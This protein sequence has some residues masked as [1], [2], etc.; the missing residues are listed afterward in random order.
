MSSAVR[1]TDVRQPPVPD[2]EHN[3]TGDA[4]MGTSTENRLFELHE[5][6]L[7]EQTAAIRELRKELTAAIL[8]LKSETARNNSRMFYVV[9]FSLTVAAG[10]IGVSVYVRAA[11]VEMG[12]G[13]AATP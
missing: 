6:H 11:G 7:K 5:A 13:P 12:T 4:E 10:A 1:H 9:M 2:S 3:V 8:A